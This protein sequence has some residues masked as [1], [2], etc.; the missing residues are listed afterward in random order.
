MDRWIV[1]RLQVTLTLATWFLALFWL[2]AV[3]PAS[4]P[5]EGGHYCAAA[6]YEQWLL[7]ILRLR[8]RWRRKSAPGTAIGARC[9]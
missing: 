2:P 4:S 9:V 5:A 8:G 3:V 1:D 6:E 7:T